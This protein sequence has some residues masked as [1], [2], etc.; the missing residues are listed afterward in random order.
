MKSVM[1]IIDSKLNA[2]LFKQHLE[3]LKES[4]IKPVTVILGDDKEDIL[5]HLKPL[6]DAILIPDNIDES[7]GD[8]DVIDNIV[9]N[10]R[11][12]KYFD[13]FDQYDLTNRLCTTS[14]ISNDCLISATYVVEI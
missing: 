11:P 3:L 6:D 14:M 5:E 13:H 2:T 1:I 12:G 9:D 7:D 4:G 8:D 10:L